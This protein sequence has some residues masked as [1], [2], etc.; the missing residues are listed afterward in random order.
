MLTGIWASLKDEIASYLERNRETNMHIPELYVYDYAKDFDEF[1]GATRFLVITD[2]CVRSGLSREKIVDIVRTS[3]TMDKAEERLVGY[4]SETVP[5]NS[6]EIVRYV[7]DHVSV[8]TRVYLW[9]FSFIG[10]FSGEYVFSD[11]SGMYD[12]RM[13]SGLDELDEKMIEEIVDAAND[14]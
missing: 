14:V 2:M 12:L 9:N 13:V 6:A 1:M 3:E 11:S 7:A 4:V 8:G 10:E 5:K